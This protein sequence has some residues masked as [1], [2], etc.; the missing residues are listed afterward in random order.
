MESRR[1]KPGLSVRQLL[2]SLALGFS[3]ILSGAANADGTE[4]LGLPSIDITR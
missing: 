4:T 2:A 1:R 3:L